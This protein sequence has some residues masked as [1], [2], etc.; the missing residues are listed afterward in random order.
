MIERGYAFAYTQY[1]F[2]FQSNFT[3][4]EEKARKS[5]IG[6]WSN[7]GTDE[8]NWIKNRGYQPF[9]L[10]EQSGNR[11]AISFLNFIKTDIASHELEATLNKTRRWKHAFKEKELIKKL[12]KDGWRI[13]HNK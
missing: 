13:Q 10:F 1:P 11:W 12:Q 5:G 6:L 7:N 3:K 2:K 4:A 8:I 9:S